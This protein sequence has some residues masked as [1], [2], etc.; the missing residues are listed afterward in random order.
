M[1]QFIDGEPFPQKI[2]IIQA[3]LDLL[4]PQANLSARDRRASPAKPFGELGGGG[5]SIGDLHDVV[6]L[7]DCADMLVTEEGLARPRVGDIHRGIEGIEQAGEALSGSN[8]FELFLFGELFMVV[9]VA[10]L[11]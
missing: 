10:V 4:I 8:L 9:P 1:P 11:F 2:T 5:H 7:P 3:E 6:Q